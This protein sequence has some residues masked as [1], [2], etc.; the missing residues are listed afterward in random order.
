[1]TGPT[2]IANRS[3]QPWPE[4]QRSA[5][6]FVILPGE[7]AMGPH[8]GVLHDFLGIERV[9]QDS[10]SV[11]VE[12]RF[13]PLD[14]ALKSSRIV[15]MDGHGKVLLVALEGAG[16]FSAGPGVLHGLNNTPSGHFVRAL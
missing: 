13:E 15:S 5:A 11:A 2:K 16:G 7:R 14:Q 8:H 12:R 10:V 9:L 1:M 6:G 3:E 4:R